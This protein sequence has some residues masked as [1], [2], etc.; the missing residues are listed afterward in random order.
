MGEHVG[1]LSLGY[2]ILPAEWQVEIPSDAEIFTGIPINPRSNYHVGSREMLWIQYKSSET[3]TKDLIQEIVFNIHKLLSPTP[4]AAKDQ[5]INGFGIFA[6]DG[7]VNGSGRSE[8]DLK[9]TNRLEIMQLPEIGS[10]KNV[11]IDITFQTTEFEETN[12]AT[13]QTTLNDTERK[14]GEQRERV[15]YMEDDR[16]SLCS[17]SEGK[18]N[19]SDGPQKKGEYSEAQKSNDSGS[20]SSESSEGSSGSR[21]SDGSGS[22]GSTSSTTLT[23][24]EVSAVFIGKL[25]IETTVGY[26]QRLTIM[27]VPTIIADRDPL[28]RVVNTITMD[29]INLKV[30]NM[31]APT[32]TKKKSHKDDLDAYFVTQLTTITVGVSC[33]NDVVEGPF[34]KTPI[35]DDF[36]LSRETSKQTAIGMGLQA[37][38]PAGARGSLAYNTN[39]TLKEVLKERTVG[40]DPQFNKAP[41]AG[42]ESWRYKV[43]SCYQ[44]DLQFSPSR[45]PM[46]AAKYWYDGRSDDS[47]PDSFIAGVETIFGQN[48]EIRYP[49]AQLGF[50]EFTF[51]RAAYI[52]HI[53]LSLEVRIK[54]MD[55]ED[56]FQIPGPGREGATLHAKVTFD[57]KETGGEKLKR[58][59]KNTGEDTNLVPTVK[60]A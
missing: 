21:D 32:S 38:F 5:T 35:H 56:Y 60:F 1:E 30:T 49:I 3:V 15:P 20:D 43:K 27:F 59:K 7:Y 48:G 39:N 46:H 29:T 14:D 53:S 22:G 40:L 4:V 37:G 18:P 10:E 25:D 6:Y 16:N 41:P 51:I 50:K 9:N 42:C 13:L 33:D 12:A 24:Q 19:T 17:R 11:N 26:S 23:A 34:D 31:T 57:K 2:D 58:E 44:T 54:R 36:I 55:V 45:P 52:R 47:F 8:W 28:S